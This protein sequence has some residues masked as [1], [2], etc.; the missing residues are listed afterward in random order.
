MIEKVRQT[1][2]RQI[3]LQYADEGKILKVLT[4]SPEIERM[5]IDS[6]LDTAGGPV[7]ALDPNNHKLWINAVTNAA[8]N[9]Q[10][11]GQL[12]IVLCS[13]AARILVK[14]STVRD[15][16][17]LIVLSVPEIAS[18]IITEGIGEISMERALESTAG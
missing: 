1:L 10:T 6:R 13:E 15:I 2:G 11:S 3:C 18:E 4:I 5:I 17:E 8:H 14:R 9:A 12:P 7:A 16:S